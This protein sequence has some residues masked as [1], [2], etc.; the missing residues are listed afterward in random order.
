MGEKAPL[1]CTVN[2]LYRVATSDFYY[3]WLIK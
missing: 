3:H 2:A 1:A